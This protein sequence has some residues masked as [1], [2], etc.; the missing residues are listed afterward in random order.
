M[1]ENFYLARQTIV[2]NHGEIMGFELLYRESESQT[3]IHNPRHATASVLVNVLNQ[4]GLKNIVGDH[5]GFINVDDSFLR[6]DFIESVPSETFIFELTADSPLDKNSKERIERLHK[7][8]YKFSLDLDSYTKSDILKDIAPF[9]TYVKI[10]ASSFEDESL[11]GFIREFQSSR[12]K[13]IASKVEDEATYNR[14]KAA[15]CDAYQG[16]FFSKPTIIKDKKLDGNHL[17]LFKLCNTIQS[18]ASISEIV[19]EFEQNPSITLQLLQFMNSGAFHFRARISS[20]HQV[21]TLL[22]RN[23]L[24]QWLM[25]LLY[26]K[27]FGNKTR[28][29]NPLI[30]MVK[31]RT[32]IMVN[33]MKM[34]KKNSTQAEQSEA[35]FVG[36]LSLMDTLMNVSLIDVLKDFHVDKAVQ[37]ALFDQSGFLGELYSIALAVET[38][39]TSL[40][41][42]FNENN[43]VNKADFEK[44]IIEVFKST[45]AMEKGSDPE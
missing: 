10:D 42:N 9:L 43:N 41:D 1:T 33:L 20:V 14:Y 8:N 17:T 28:F 36:I 15:G 39:D 11:K 40:I 27:N 4:S 30:L 24:V 26:S 16:Y 38:F 21:I 45:V 13:F 12:L 44:M 19:K 29:Q 32:E 3:N 6:H 2:D 31:Q 23:T 35:Y 22:G 18:G 25:L 5:L 37:D 34:V 7:K